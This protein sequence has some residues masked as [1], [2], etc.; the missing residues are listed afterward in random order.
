MKQAMVIITAFVA[1]FLQ[2]FRLPS[3]KRVLVHEILWIQILS[4]GIVGAF[5]IGALYWGGQWVLQD[6]Y[7]RWALQWTEELNELGSPLYL[8]DDSE[9]LLRLESFVKRY[10]EIGRVAYFRPDG[11]PLFSIDGDA[12]LEPPGRLSESML[13]EARAL[14]GSDQPYL[15]QSSILN[16]RQFEIMAPVW[17]ESLADDG[18]FAFDPAVALTES[19]T[20]LIG[21]V[22]MHLDFIIF[23]DRLLANIKVAIM[24]LLVLLTAFALYGRRVLRRALASI[25]DLQDPIQELARGNLKVKFEPAEHR[26]ISDIVEALETTATALS[27]RD[28]ML[29]ELA[30]HDNLTGLFNRRRFMEELNVELANIAV[31]EHSSALFFIDLDQ[32]KYVNDTCGHH[33]GDRLIRKVADE[34]I[35]SVSEN[36]IVARFGG[37]EFVILHCGTDERSVRDMAESILSNMRR[38]AHVEDERVFHIHCSIGVT[39]IDRAKANPDEIIAEADIACREA[40]SAGRNRMQFFEKSSHFVERAS[41]DVGWMNRLRNAVDADS[42]ELRFQPINQIDSGAT[43]HHEVLLRLRGDDGKLLSPDAFL[44]SAVRF[45]LMSE[46]DLW[47]IRHS[48]EAYAEYVEESPQLRLSINLSANAFESDNLS[49]YVAS[50]FAEHGVP[51]NRIIFEITESL[52]VRRPRHVELQIDALREMGCKLALDDFGTGYSSFSYLQKL[53]FDFIKIDGSFVHD[54]LNNPV[55]QKMIK[56]IAEV[57]REANMQTV[58]EYV[59]DAE[60]LELLGEL[61]VDL[62]QGFFVGRPTRR[63]LYKSTPISL[64]SRRNRRTWQN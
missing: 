36:D 14:V 63:P 64:S 52:A 35:R 51:A 5:A 11:A 58:A 17:T 13:E 61:G 44:P 48:A 22:G 10:P 45:G 34:L 30:N 38:L 18:L 41:S 55:D 37:D 16:P 25:S 53:H 9:A 19:K 26:E 50:V 62:A 3:S 28:A 32:F 29:M 59:Q 1:R 24:I 27:E 56:L 20:E 2:R 54:I 8:S 40:K 4:A 15:L 31:H 60:S 57:G 49:E 39:M 43:K 6:N 12:K 46:I 42:F 33:A 21:F 47:A 23:H 7:S